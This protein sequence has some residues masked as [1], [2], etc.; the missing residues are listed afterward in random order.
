MFQCFFSRYAVIE[1]NYVAANEVSKAGYGVMDLHYLLQFQQLRRR[2]DGIYW[3]GPA[4]RLITNLIITN[5]QLWQRNEEDENGAR[6][7]E[8]HVCVG[9]SCCRRSKRF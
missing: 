5:V 1:A 4:N 3:I 8:M 9:S 2:K 6:E 7:E